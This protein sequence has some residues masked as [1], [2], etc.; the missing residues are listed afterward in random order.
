MGLFDFAS[1]IGNKVFGGGD[2]PSEKITEELLKADLNINDLSATF[3]EG[4]V[5]LTGDTTDSVAAEK[6]ILIVGNM[7]GVGQV[8][9]NMSM[10]IAA[11]NTADLEYYEIQ[12]GDT[13][14]KIAASYYGNANAYMQIFEANREVIG[15]P[16]LIFVGQKIRIPMQAA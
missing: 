14:S 12:S 1:S 9:N 11:E 6:A 13:L 10:P 2:D 16:D 8:V 7:D 4:V 3:A 5:T 15:D